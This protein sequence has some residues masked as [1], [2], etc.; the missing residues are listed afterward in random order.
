MKAHG[1]CT[2]AHYEKG[3]SHCHH[4]QPHLHYTPEIYFGKYIL[5]MQVCELMGLRDTNL[6][7][8]QD[9]CLSTSVERWWQL[10]NSTH[11]DHF[12]R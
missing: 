5:V 12:Q 1:T 11:W 3:K 2:A 6:M 7:Y 9:H 4:H 10:K 8:T